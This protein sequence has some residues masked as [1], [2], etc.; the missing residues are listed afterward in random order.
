[1]YSNFSRGVTQSSHNFKLQHKKAIKELD[2]S[3]YSFFLTT[4]RPWN[5]LPKHIVKSSSLMSFKTKTSA[6][7][8][9]KFILIIIHIDF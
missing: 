5:N 6:H 2:V 7:F 9:D 3:F 1:M 4:I 8:N